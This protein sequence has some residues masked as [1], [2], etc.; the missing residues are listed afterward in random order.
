M[1]S[2]LNKTATVFYCKHFIKISSYLTA[3]LGT[4]S[5][6][7]ECHEIDLFATGF[8]PGLDLHGVDK[9]TGDT[10]A[11]ASYGSNASS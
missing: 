10:S 11:A 3:L 1:I 7:E 8:I 2:C 4:G 6:K 5:A 9:K